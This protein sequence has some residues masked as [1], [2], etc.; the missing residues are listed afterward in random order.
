VATAQPA[1]APLSEMA[2]NLTR[3]IAK[4]HR[5]VP[6]Q[7]FHMGLDFSRN[8]AGARLAEG[9]YVA[10]QVPERLQTV[11]N[12]NDWVLDRGSGQI[13][14]RTDRSELVPYNYVTFGVTKYSEE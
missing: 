9:A 3:G 7:E 6:V 11:W 12:W 2:Y 8:P 4:R 13:V 10:V 1:I 5:N 14:R